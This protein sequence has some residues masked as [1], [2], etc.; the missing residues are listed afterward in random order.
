MVI[1][2]PYCREPNLFFEHKLPWRI[3]LNE[4]QDQNS[5]PPN[6]IVEFKCI[7]CPRNI[8]LSTCGKRLSYKQYPSSLRC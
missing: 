7:L 6:D 2:C 3:S 1:R 4:P 5:L 8:R